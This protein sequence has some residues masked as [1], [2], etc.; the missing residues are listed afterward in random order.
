MDQQYAFLDLETTGLSPEA[1]EILE[2]A[3]LDAEENVL[4]ESLIRP[5]HIQTAHPKALE[6]NG[7]AANPSRWKT[8][9][10][11]NEVAPKVMDLLAGKVLVGHNIDRFDLG[12]VRRH[13]EKA[14]QDVSRITGQTVD[15]MNLAK[16][17]L[18][19]KGLKTKKLHDVCDFLGIS[20]DGEHTAKADVK[21]TIKAFHAMRTASAKPSARPSA[22]PSN[23]HAP[24]LWS[25]PEC[26]LGTWLKLPEHPA[27][28]CY[29]GKLFGVA[30]ITAT[31]AWYGAVIREGTEYERVSFNL[32]GSNGAEIKE[33]LERAA[34]F[35][36]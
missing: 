29:F 19:P 10:T 16:E 3:I 20:N 25:L 15:T 32:T 27:I 8:A 18:V 22:R 14:G 11:W 13:L 6:V 4:F 17:H 35:R 36:R 24:S 21:R 2:I 34:G 1:H 26:P 28:V 9:P 33:K 30:K 7:Y 12:F 23:N 5:L 31:G